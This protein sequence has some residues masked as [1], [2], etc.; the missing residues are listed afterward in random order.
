MLQGRVLSA[1]AFSA[2]RPFPI[3]KFVEIV[4]G[5]YA[6]V[7]GGFEVL[8]I[9]RFFQRNDPG[10]PARSGIDR[11]SQAAG[12]SQHQ[13]R[14]N[15]HACLDKLPAF[16]PD[17]PVCNLGRSDLSRSVYPHPKSPVKKHAELLPGG[18]AG[19]RCYTLE[20]F[21]MKILS[22]ATAISPET[23]LCAPSDSPG[24]HLYRCQLNNTLRKGYPVFPPAYSGP[25]IPAHG[26][27]ALPRWVSGKFQPA[28]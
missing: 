16:Q 17:F 11:R 24:N 20:P 14:A 23:G 13:S 22:P 19:Q 7:P 28:G 12:T 21:Q 8:T 2:R 9:I 1:S 18:K 3:A 10:I 25:G 27:P 5:G 15:R 6:L 4:V 26:F